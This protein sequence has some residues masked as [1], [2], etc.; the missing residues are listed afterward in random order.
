VTALADPRAALGPLWASAG[1]TERVCSVVG[2]ALIGSGLLHLVVFAVDGGPWH[3]PV[4]WRKP[5]T[6]GLSFG[7]TLLTVGWLMAY[8]PLPG[9][10]GRFLLGVFAL[11]CCV[12]VGGI[13]VQAW[14]HVPSHVNRETPFDSAI[15]TALA[16]GGGVLVI[17]LGTLGVAAFRARVA[18]S[19]RLALRAGFTSLM[20]GLVTGAAMIARG[21]AE[22]NGGRQQRAYEV[23]GFLK[24]VHGVSLH[25]VLVLPALAWLLSFTGWDEARRARAVAFG[26]A[27]YGVAIIVA[28]G[29]SLA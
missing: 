26:A 24:P 13:T 19:M 5:V 25:G 23:L 21:V 3:G 27:G 12:E 8:L 4:S 16:A 22:V 17:V 15:S 10:W 29:Y 1:R 6:F 9:R 11:D 7:L 2:L 18:P 28:L 20:I 14:R